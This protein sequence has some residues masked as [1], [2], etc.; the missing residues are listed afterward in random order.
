MKAFT[1]RRPFMRIL[2]T[3]FLSLALCYTAQA[4]DTPKLDAFLD[5]LSFKSTDVRLPSARAIIHG[6]KDFQVLEARDAQRVLEELW[7]NPPDDSVLGMIVP[8]ATKLSDDHAWAVVLTYADEGHVSDADAQA[9]DY[10]EMLKELQES[11][12]A[13]N[14]QREQAGF[15]RV[16]LVGWAESP[17]YDAASNKL[18]WAKD[19]RFDG[20][21]AHTLNY[22]VRALGR[23][24]YL[25]MNAVASLEDL[26]AIKAAMPTVIAMAEFEA[27]ARYADFDASTDRTAEYGLAAL[28]GGGIAAKSGLLAKIFALL[29]AAK[30]LVILALG[31]LVVGI[32]KLL[33]RNKEKNPS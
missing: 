19:L 12:A 22:D 13:A 18:Y 4:Q 27:G 14:Q 5:S 25:S 29:L 30:K 24:G 32:G 2:S 15:G 8:A 17:R 6:S 21:E 9:I 10:S 23:S 20:A 1:R 7:G 3:L 31:A 26:A 11:T 33:G 28:I 16:D